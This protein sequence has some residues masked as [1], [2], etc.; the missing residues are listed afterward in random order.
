VLQVGIKRQIRYTSACNNDNQIQM[1]LR[2]GTISIYIGLRFLVGIVAVFTL[3]SILIFLIDFVEMLRQADKRGGADVMR[4][5]WLSILRIPSFTEMIMPF[6]A[7]IGSMG[8]F[9]LLNRSSELVVMRAA[10][11][12]VWQ[13]VIPGV[14]VAFAIGIGTT[15]LYNPL[16]AKAKQKAELL[17]A[18]MSGKKASIF[19]IGKKNTGNWLR[20]DGAD[21]QSVIHANNVAAHGTILHGVSVFQFDINHK[22]TAR[23]EAENAILKGGHWLLKNVWVSETAKPPEFFNNYV[24][25]TF[26]TK[27]Q[28]RDSIGSVDSVSFWEMPRF[29]EIAVKAGLPATRYKVQYQQLLARPMILVIMVLL[30]AT[31]SLRPFRFGGV[32]NLIIAGLLFGFMFFIA[33]EISRSL[34]LSGALPPAVGVWTPLWVVFLLATTLLLY[35]EDG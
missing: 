10:G 34:G 19:N 31:C 6:A 13:L 8:A 32:Q 30:A 3:C 17:L 4:V 2:L 22:F 21:G 14:I 11:M 18:E 20:Q 5:I 28:I 16:A 27:T 7:L 12:S 35:Q 23:L 26:L 33:M 29:I 24:L 15:T 9:M 1:N 25:S